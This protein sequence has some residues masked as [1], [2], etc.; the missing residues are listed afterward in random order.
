MKVLYVEDDP[1]DIL[2]FDRFVDCEKPD[3]ECLKAESVAQAL[4]LM[5]EHEFNAV[6][7]DYRL[8]DGN[9][10]DILKATRRCPVIIIT[11]AGNEEIAINAMKLGAVDYVVKDIDRNY[12]K[13]IPIIVQNAIKR[14]ET[15]KQNRLLS[16]AIMSITDGICISDISDSILFVNQAFCT[17]HEYLTEELIGKTCSCICKDRQEYENILHI[18]TGHS[19]VNWSGESV[20]VAKSGRSFPVLISRSVVLDQNK[21]PMALVMICRDM[22]EIKAIENE[23]NLIEKTET[24]SIDEPQAAMSVCIGCG[25]VHEADGAWIPIVEML[26]RLSGLTHRYDICPDCRSRMA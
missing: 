10:F 3:C 23:S 19:D 8:G 5:E 20:H 14:W 26:K 16:H 4:S 18:L 13:A 6:I 9:A 12:L 1:V 2:A 25:S 21:L 15:E 24:Q 7:T 11:G 22:T 17:M